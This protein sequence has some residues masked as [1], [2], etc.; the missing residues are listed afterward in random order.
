[1]LS[2]PKPNEQQSARI[3]AAQRL[4]E[5]SWMAAEEWY[6]PAAGTAM[7]SAVMPPARPPMY[8]LRPLSLG[9]VLD[10]TFTVYKSRFWLF[11]GLGSVCAAL[12]ALLGAVQ[13]L[14][15]HL[16]PPVT[17]RPPVGVAGPPIFPS[18]LTPA[19]GIGMAIVFLVFTV[20]YLLAFVVTQAA[21]V[22]ALSEV[23]LGRTTTIA[24]SVQAT[25]RK[26]YR[27]TA[28]GIWQACSMMWIPTLAGGGG[29][30]LLTFGGTGLK[31]VGGLL[32]FLAFTG[33]MVAGVILGLRNSLGI[34]ASVIEGLTVRPS[35]RRSKVLTQGA[36]TRVFVVGLVAGALGYAASLLQM[37]LM[38]VVM[39]AMMK[40]GRAVGSEICMLLLGFVGRALV[41]PVLMIGVSLVYFDQR[42]KLEAFDL[43]V[44]LGE[45]IAPVVM[46]AQAAVAV[47][48]VAET[49]VMA[50][51]AVVEHE[52]GTPEAGEHE[53]GQTDDAAEL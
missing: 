25:I 29:F 30:L 53:A 48:P 37:P 10:R 20:L 52:T 2:F 32:V 21:T 18:F 22:Y 3:Q 45:E 35:M 38:F 31:V 51:P 5:E 19:F 49:L 36:K 47:T 44:L 15:L 43:A 1:M 41:Q 24:E 8:E 23:Y 33:G 39:F 6:T 40:G 16:M 12:Q 50:A 34:Q 46:P 7:A 17:A 26:W 13:L 28:I 14:P 27:Y 42:V 9:E 4:Y 11:V